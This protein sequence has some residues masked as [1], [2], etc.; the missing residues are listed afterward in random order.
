MKGSI[1]LLAKV[2]KEFKNLD[3]QLDYLHKEKNIYFQDRDLAKNI[4]LD[5][6]Y[7]NL[8][9]SGKIKFVVDIS[10]NNHKY[11]P[12]QFEEWSR[13]F[14]DDCQVS[15]FLMNNLIE[16]ERIINSRTSF[17]VGE[18]IEKELLSKKQHNEIAEIIINAKIENL[19][20]Y[21]G[22]ETW[23]YISKMTFGNLKNILF[24]LLN[25]DKKTFNKIFSGYVFLQKGSIP[26]LKHRISDIVLLRN[27]LFHFTPL[28][29]FLVYATGKNGNYYNRFRIKIVNFI[30]DLKPNQDILRIMKTLTECSNSF[31]KIKNSHLS[32]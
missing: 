9:S 14:L 6:N 17:Y 8:V 3:D 16:F 26:Q 7:Y 20:D 30:Y 1:Q 27:Y 22:K 15:E 12:S 24:W 21:I 31:I 5:Y 18:L 29:L 13:Y 28:T 11:N 23:K 10:N 4:L 19:D 25:S 2:Y 32:D